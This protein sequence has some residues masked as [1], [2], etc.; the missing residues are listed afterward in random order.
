MRR[1]AGIALA[2]ALA[3]NPARGEGLAAARGPTSLAPVMPEAAQEVDIEEHLGRTLDPTLALTD[4]DGRRVALGDYLG[5]SA[6]I[7]LVLAYY[8]CPML[9][10]LVLRGAV[11]GLLG[12]EYRL[13]GDYR[14]LTVSFDPRDT[15]EAARKKRESTL[16][17]LGQSG[18][19]PLGPAEWPF[20][21][22][23]ERETHALAGAIGFRYAYDAKTDQYAHPAAIV[24]LT[25]GGRISRYLYGVSWSPRDLRLALV[26]AGE[27]RVGT[28]V[29]RVIMSCYH[30]DPTSR[31]YA[32]YVAGF[33]RLGG[34]MILFTVMGVLGLLLQA[35]RRARAGG[36]P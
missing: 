16:A 9:C 20:L 30:Y 33:L 29:D 31:A 23:G 28:I 17:A 11:S 21:V 22:G 12:L 36:S 35:E 8:R 2:C 6:P 7:V 4:M 18:H 19:G 24:I 25:P 1:F 34:G 14:A 13:G 26:E 15:P 10:G 27:G 3:A 32:P 5:G